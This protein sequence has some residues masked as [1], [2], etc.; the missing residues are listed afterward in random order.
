MC[1]ET[2]PLRL[3]LDGG[4][5]CVGERPHAD[6]AGDEM[7]AFDLIVRLFGLLLG[8]AMGEVLAGL[9]RTIRLKAG[10]TAVAASRVRVGWLTPLLGVLVIVSQLSFWLTFYELHG[11]MPLNLLA[12]LGLALV[13]GGF[14][15]ISSFVFPA[16]PAIW[17]DFDAYYFK[18]RRTV[19][20]G[21]M[22]I[23]LAALAYLVALALNGFTIQVTTGTPSAISNALALSGFPVLVALAIVRGRGASL[24]LLLAANAIP[25]VEALVGAR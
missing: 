23:E 12:L 9:A 13:V 24:A 18:V 15:V 2:Q 14:Y 3:A 5:T 20:G 4:R 6:F 22:A 21:L 19:I 17:P 10:L 7:S 11:R 16:D 8:L 25:V 1:V